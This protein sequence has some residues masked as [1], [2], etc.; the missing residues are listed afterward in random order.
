LTNPA[1]RSVTADVTDQIYLGTTQTTTVGP[2]FD[3]GP[4][5]IPANTT[6]TLTHTFVDSVNLSP[7]ASPTIAY[8]DKA[9]ATYTDTITGVPEGSLTAAATS[10]VTQLTGTNGTATI[11]DQE[12]I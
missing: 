3:S 5:V 2:L 4:V 9:T 6:T 7:P 10:P 8:N 11:T 1:A 12:D